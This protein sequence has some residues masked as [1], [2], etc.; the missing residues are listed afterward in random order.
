MKKAKKILSALLAMTMLFSVM[1]VGVEAVRYQYK[2]SGISN[3]NAIDQP[4]LTTNQ[5]GT[6]LLDELDRMLA[7]ENIV[8]SFDLGGLATLTID[9][10]SID[11]TRASIIDLWGSV[12][13]L[14]GLVG[15]DV[16]N[17]NLSALVNDWKPRDA[18][19]VADIHV[20]YCLFQFLAD[21]SAILK[22]AANNTLNLGMIGN[23]VDI[24]LDLQQMIKE[25]LYKKAYPGQ[26]V[27][28]QITETVDTMLQNIIDF[29][30]VGEIDPET[31]EHDGFFPELSGHIDL[32]GQSFYDLIEEGFRIFWNEM[33]VDL[34]NTKVKAYVRQMCGVVYSPEFPEGDESN[35]NEYADLININ[36]EIS[37]IDFSQYGANETFIDNINDILGMVIEEVAEFDIA[38]VYGN[39]S[40]FLSNIV[41][42]GKEIVKMTGSALFADFVEVKTD[43]EI[44][45]MTDMQFITYLIR[46]TVNGSD[47]GIDIPN[48]IETLLELA[49]YSAKV[50]VSDIIPSQYQTYKN[51]P[52]NETESLELMLSDVAA[53]FMMQHTDIYMEYGDPLHDPASQYGDRM[54]AAMDWVFDNYGGFLSNINSTGW[55]ALNEVFFSL[56]PSEWIQLKNG[57]PRDDLYDLI[58]NDV[59]YNII[60]LNFDGL[61]E[62]LE[63]NTNP[64]EGLNNSVTH[65]LV[66]YVK[67]I[68]NFIL[69]NTATPAYNSFEDLISKTKLPTLVE[70]LINNLNANIRT[71]MPSLIPIL[72][73]ALNL[74]SEQ[75][76]AFPYVSLPSEISG[77]QPFYINNQSSG[78]N[79]AYK[80]VNGWMLATGRDNLY[81][82]RILDATTN[83]PGVSV[84]YNGQKIINISGNLDLNGG[85][86]MYFDISGTPTK[87][88]TLVVTIKLDV[89]NEFGQVMTPA[90][91]IHTSYAFVTSDKDDGKEEVKIDSTTSNYHYLTYK[92]VSYLNQN[93]S[94]SKLGDYSITLRRNVEDGN[95]HN[96]PAKITQ[97]GGSNIDY[98]IANSGIVPNSFA[99]ID[100]DGNGGMWDANPYDASAVTEESPRPDD[101]MYISEFS[102]SASK[103]SMNGPA[104]NLQ[105]QHF[106]YLYNDYDL[107]SLVSGEIKA[108]RQPS[109]YNPG[110]YT[111]TYIDEFG[112]EQS[113]NVN[114]TAVWNEYVNAIADGV[115]VVYRPRNVFTFP[116]THEDNY[117]Q[118]A[119]TLEETIAKLEA[120]EVSSGGSSLKSVLETY[121]PQNHTIEIDPETNEEIEVPFEFYD[122]NYRFFAEDDYYRHTYLRFKP[123]RNAA[124]SI[125]G[126][127][128]AEEPEVVSAIE[129]AYVEHRLQLYGSRLIR[130]RAYTEALVDTI[131]AI[132]AANYN[133]AVYT[134]ESWE[135]FD[136][137]YNFATQTVAE[138][139]GT[140]VLG[141]I[142]TTEG[143]RQSQVTKAR[144]ELIEASKRLVSSADYTAFNNQLIAAGNVGAQSLYTVSSWE[145][146]DI[147]YD[148]ALNMPLD[149]LDT[150]DNQQ[151]IDD[152]TQALANAING[153][154]YIA[155]YTQLDL[156]IADAQGYINNESLY[157]VETFGIFDS[158]YNVAIAIDRDLSQ[159]SQSTIDDAALNLADAIAGLQLAAQAGVEVV[160]GSSVVINKEISSFYGNKFVYGLS[161][162][163]PMIS[164]NLNPT[165]G[166]TVAITP[167]ANGGEST[168]A[169]VTVRD[170]SN[171]II[172]TYEVILF[173]DING[174]GSTDGLDSSMLV[175]VVNQKG[176]LY[177]Q[178]FGFA[179]ANAYSMACDINADGSI[180]GIDSSA[181]DSSVMGQGFILQ[182]YDP[183][184]YFWAM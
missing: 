33:G 35:L 134:A 115:S 25:M 181:M 91:I 18:A 105:L 167:N 151:R 62:L 163:M 36:F 76:F 98:D 165:G 129:M 128:E 176:T 79:T 20:L 80:Y 51:L 108:N 160:E 135:D 1:S 85:E 72:C 123:E 116:T 14:L 63:R 4:V 11:K 114:G 16:K 32:D 15:G 40:Y 52:L 61:F 86:L 162:W 131:A 101:G 29:L 78:L 148:V 23:F 27:P 70:N 56:L 113:E 139:I 99:T 164:G 47:S 168:G 118:Y 12:Q 124:R 50:I 19:G 65:I 59:I 137:A 17:L 153:L 28:E 133:E 38:W 60:N 154:A 172:E 75:E 100:T 141:N 10:S 126:K 93:T 49:V 31:G 150:I 87:N 119:T 68:I 90:P 102:Y 132:D 92:K 84:T 43:Q 140:T 112:I 144:E 37:E 103:T 109:Q 155:N 180:D 64:G 107:P 81:K 7:K 9:A 177:E 120:G 66:N 173:G 125:I 146:F 54:E 145:A 34:F 143:L 178:C 21:N 46:S 69:P 179:I 174:D 184:N 88:Q 82:Y 22:K 30:L 95:T 67:N 106:V 8:E 159:S 74:S 183:S 170:S 117:E 73:M 152:A 182:N 122:E 130:V 169:T 171:A 2:D 6:M 55:D 147:A 44:D 41:A 138:D 156:A 58:F 89:L 149:L 48:N 157:T 5:Y 71:M 57:Q 77:A 3:Y 142:L 121:S 111:Y 166:A 26:V 83:Q 45:A 161:S 127:L 97:P 13:P 175:N 42:A 110:N 24:D 39:N 104:E 96:Y 94:L 158:A 136:N 53:K